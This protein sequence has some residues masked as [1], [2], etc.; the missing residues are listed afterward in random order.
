M[1]TFIGQVNRGQYSA[2]R[3]TLPGKAIAELKSTTPG[4][5]MLLSL[6]EWQ[7][8]VA[9]G[10]QIP[11]PEANSGGV[12]WTAR[13]TPLWVWIAGAAVPTAPVGTSL[14]NAALSHRRNRY[15]FTDVLFGSLLIQ[16]P[17]ATFLP[18]SGDLLVY[19]SSV[20]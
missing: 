2:L 15:R 5:R 19:K 16:G 11:S 20:A 1:H 6:L 4:S 14:A 10:T 8:R 12:R 18:K 9:G 7:G 13:A 17:V 3:A